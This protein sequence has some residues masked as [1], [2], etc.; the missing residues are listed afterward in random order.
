MSEL[1]GT[2]A[3]SRRVLLLLAASDVTVLRLAV[4]PLSSAKL[5]SALANLVE[6]R[7]IGD[8]ADC[9]I[10]AGKPNG[11]MRTIALVQRAWLDRLLDT[12]AALGAQH[13]EA[14]PAQLCLAYHAD[15]ANGVTAAIDEQDGGIEITLGGS[16]QDG[17][18]LTLAH[19]P[20]TPAART[21][22]AALSTL[23]GKARITL[24]VAQS[25]LSDYRKILDE[26]TVPSPYIRVAADDWSHWIVPPRE[27][28]P[29][30]AAASGRGNI[31]TLN[32]HAWRW[33]LALAASVLLINAVALNVDWW[34]LSRE[35]RALRATM[36]QSYRQAYPEES[37]I[38]D[39]LAQ[40]QQKITA[41]RQTSGTGAA[42]DFIP[43]S[44][45]F[46]EAWNALGEPAKQ[47]SSIASLSYRERQ[48]FVQLQPF[49][50]QAGTP[51]PRQLS[52]QMTQQMK[53]TLKKYGL[54]LDLAPEVS[55]AIVWRIGAAQ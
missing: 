5:K 16:A 4:P 54:A 9:V 38:I 15:H 1:K 27:V 22:L 39:P 41:A 31:G 44:A 47:G 17:I 12:L 36:M 21:A 51:P 34:Q 35:S 7:I 26:S 55:G 18:G 43:L 29:N 10:A 37:V 13:I 20:G 28:M 8:P 25:A 46:G 32:W 42:D 49:P 50:S 6:D 33:P 24:Y 45:A 14:L 23:A 19:E 11:G 2:L 53:S 48:L 3:R 40:M 52:E 30:L